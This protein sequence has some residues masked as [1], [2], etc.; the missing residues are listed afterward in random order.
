M[1]SRRNRE[2]YFSM[3]PEVESSQLSLKYLVFV[4]STFKSHFDNQDK[5]VKIFI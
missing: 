3:F 5:C 1:F 2:K 4:K